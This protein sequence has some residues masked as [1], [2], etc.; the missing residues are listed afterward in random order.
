M[1]N[2]Q[3]EY[4]QAT[5][6]TAHSLRSIAQSNQ[7]ERLSTLSLPEIETTVEMIARL[8]PA[9]N[10]PGMILSG[11]ARLSGR[12]AAPQLAR[13]DVNLLFSGVE[14]VLDKAVYGS[15]FA[16]PAA[17][18][19]AYQQLL[20]LAGKDMEESFPEGLWQFYADYSLR[21]D[22]ARYA[23]ETHGF[24]TVLRHHQIPLSP[25][26]R[27]TAWTMAA[28]TTL[29]QYHEWLANEWRERVYTAILQDVAQAAPVV[30]AAPY[31]PQLEHIYKEWGQKRPYGR[32]KDV[33]SSE[34]YAAYR[35]RQFDTFLREVLNQLDE[36]TRYAWNQQ[37]Q[38]A[39]PHLAQ[40]Q[41][42]LSILA[43]LAPN[44]YGEVRQPIAL[45]DAC[46]GLIYQDR[47]YL[48][49][50]C[51]PGGQQPATVHQVQAHIAAI[52][53]QPA[54]RSAMPLSTLATLQRQEWATLRGEL[55]QTLGQSLD[56]LRC[57]PILIN[58][59]PQSAQAPLTDIRQA[60]RGVGDHPLTLFDAQKSFVFDFSHIFFDGAWAAALAEIMT[61]EALSWAVYLR[62]TAADEPLEAIM[63][64]P[65]RLPFERSESIFIQKAQRVTAEVSAETELAQVKPILALRKLFKM[66]SD[67]LQLTVNDLLIL[68]RAVH[69]VTYQ[70]DAR[71]LASLN[72]LGQDIKM[73]TAVQQAILAS[74]PYE[75]PPAMLI[76]I[77]ASH[78]DPKERIYP[79]VFEV[80]LHEL[81]LLAIHQQTLSALATYE[82]ANPA[83]RS[84][85]YATF[86]QLQRDYLGT[87]AGFGQVLSHAKTIAMQAES[88]SQ[89]AMKL[90]AHLPVP[91]QRLL[92]QIPNRFDVLNDLI[93]GREVFSNVGA[94]ADG[95]TLL[96]FSSAKDDN[97]KKTLVWGV[98][99]DTNKVMRLSLRDFRP[100]VAAFVAL[101]QRQV[102]QQLTQHY[103]DS[104]ARG[105]NGFINDLQRITRTSRETQLHRY[106][107]PS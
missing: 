11:L 84:Q 76:P 18:I 82:Q 105:L 80:P 69:A 106:E 24:D 21:E 86:D 47:Y 20:K 49:P 23:V 53:R 81:N 94:V 52:M 65:L 97:Q 89:G 26:N 59:D 60:E 4:D 12:R 87:L 104:Y 74:Q 42:Q 85:A 16:G 46:V 57:A 71:L 48:I 7:M 78:H 27:V 55:N 32:G 30:Q 95:S 64:R 58:A 90:L 41:Q 5:Q 14:S 17:V 15:F 66:R 29:H 67:L 33:G 37:V 83:T 93:K 91:L 38:Q 98:I 9:G 2:N 62:D 92:D 6:T 102:A 36:Q 70:P 54:G 50:A 10:V 34:T 31:T 101:G 73:E 51:A 68:Y 75:H 63:S 1:T 44:S 25:V 35:R 40:F 56:Q 100:H 107:R 79:L 96:R 72:G 39:K 13:R 28:I 77:D 22:T 61:R 88:S 103:L 19:W 43:Y 3:K 45:S 8:L 99:T